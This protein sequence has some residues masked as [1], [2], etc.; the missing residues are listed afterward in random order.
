MF[1]ISNR[2]G[3][4]QITGGS[5]SR[6]EDVCLSPTMCINLPAQLAVLQIYS[7][8]MSERLSPKFTEQAFAGLPRRSAF[9]ACRGVCVGVPHSPPQERLEP[10]QQGVLPSCWLRARSGDRVSRRKYERPTREQTWDNV[11]AKS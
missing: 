5:E 2:R 6:M 10:S 8:L 3:I 4:L 9:E 1:T 11:I 7:T